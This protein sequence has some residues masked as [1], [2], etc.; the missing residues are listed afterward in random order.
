MQPATTTHYMQEHYMQPA[1][2]ERKSF[3]IPRSHG[4]RTTAHCT[5][6]LWA[7]ALSCSSCRLRHNDKDVVPSIKRGLRSSFDRGG[8]SLSDSLRPAQPNTRCE[9]TTDDK[10]ITH[11][12]QLISTHNAKPLLEHLKERRHTRRSSRG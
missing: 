5:T 4:T 7:H 12:A 1:T 6:L 11:N 10:F 8:K 2:T 9:T 3:G